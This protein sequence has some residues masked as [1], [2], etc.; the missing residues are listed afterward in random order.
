MSAAPMRVCWGCDTR[1]PRVERYCE[2]CGADQWNPP[3]GANVSDHSWRTN[4]YVRREETH[5][6]LPTQ[7][8]TA[9]GVVII[10]TLLL[11]STWF[12]LAIWL[13]G[14]V[15]PPEAEEFLAVEVLTLDDYLSSGR[16][17]LASVASIGLT[18]ATWSITVN[19]VG[20][21]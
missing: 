6:Q 9:A 17:F 5:G 16:V 13:F 7:A 15:N 1:I 12:W 18:V 3:Q 11:L 20:N 14:V 4:D 19:L 8:I 10:A 21:D 2:H